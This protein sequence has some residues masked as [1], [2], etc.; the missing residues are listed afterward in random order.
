MRYLRFEPP[1]MPPLPSNITVRPFQPGDE[2]AWIGLL[3]RN[4]ELGT[5]DQS[6]FDA[7]HASAV[8]A[9]MIVACDGG[10]L[11]AACGVHD[12][13]YRG[14][15]AW[16]I[17]LVARDPEYGRMGL[18]AAVTSASLRA[19]MQM[20]PRVIYLETDDHRL[21]AIKMYR[22]LGFSRVANTRGYRRRWRAVEDAIAA[23]EAKLPS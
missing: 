1:E 14:E 17:G 3:N 23:S 9:G 21:P 18:G 11:V 6:R 12:R 16:E 15:P 10:R 7:L 2:E 5:W 4:G 22:R 20:E 13:W 8:S 19:A